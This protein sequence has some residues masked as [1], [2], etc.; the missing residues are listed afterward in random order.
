[1]QYRIKNDQFKEEEAKGQVDQ[2]Q[3]VL[4]QKE[5][6]AARAR[7]IELVRLLSHHRNETVRLTSQAVRHDEG[8]KAKQRELEKVSERRA[9]FPQQ[10]EGKEIQAAAT[11]AHVSEIQKALTALDI[12]QQADT[13]QLSTLEKSIQETR[14]RLASLDAEKLSLERWL[15][16]NPVAL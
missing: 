10:V 11:Q 3:C 1:K 16:Q 7:L 13:E 14:E 5:M 4:L 2:N 12:A 9:A 8:A 6:E 15:G